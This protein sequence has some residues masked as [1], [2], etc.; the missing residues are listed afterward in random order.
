MK[1][2]ILSFALLAT[3]ISAVAV[4]CSSSEKATVSDSNTMDSPMVDTTKMMDTTKMD[5]TRKM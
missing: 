5:T 2:Q 1:K 3:M 4:G